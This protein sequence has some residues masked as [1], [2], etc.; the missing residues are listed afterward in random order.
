[1]AARRS[2]PARARRARDRRARRACSLRRGGGWD[3]DA[4]E[5][6][7]TR[8]WQLIRAPRIRGSSALAAN[9]LDEALAGTASGQVDVRGLVNPAALLGGEL[10]ALGKTLLLTDD[11]GLVDLDALGLRERVEG[12]LQPQPLD[13]GLAALT[14]QLLR[15][16]ARVL[17][18]A[19]QRHAHRLQAR[20]EVGELA[21]DLAL[22]HG[23]GQVDGHVVAE[24][25]ER[26]R[27]EGL[28][29]PAGRGAGWRGGGRVAPPPPP[30]Q[31]AVF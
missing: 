14:A 3:G 17:H 20:V 23:L 27:L 24:R 10:A 12:Q 11:G 25:F 19:V 4:G 13:G 6:S 28:A 22:H 9:D 8:L 31:V 18:V 26:R 21:I 7:T 1:M 30:P 29:G 5:G 15:A 16:R 2:P